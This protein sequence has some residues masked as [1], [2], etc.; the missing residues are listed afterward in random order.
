[1]DS[2][3]TGASGHCLKPFT[4]QLT[5]CTFLSQFPHWLVLPYQVAQ[6]AAREDTAATA[7]SPSDEPAPGGSTN[8]RL[9]AAATATPVGAAHPAAPVP[10]LVADAPAVSAKGACT[11]QL[12]ATPAQVMLTSFAPDQ[13]LLKRSACP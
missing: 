1:M 13:A 7:A 5:V 11:T 4:F 12:D 8:G 2:N 9:A 6:L 10:P 3:M